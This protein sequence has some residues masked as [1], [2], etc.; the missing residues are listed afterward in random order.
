MPNQVLRNS[1][2]Q[3]AASRTYPLSPSTLTE[4]IQL[5]REQINQFPTA[6]LQA[7]A[8]RS[9]LTLFTGVFG[10]A[11]IAWTGWVGWLSSVGVESLGTALGLGALT[12]LV[13]L[14]VVVTNWAKG[15]R[16]WWD[17]WKRIQ[18]GFE[19]DLKVR[20]C[21]AVE[22]WWASNTNGH[23]SDAIGRCCGEAGDGCSSYS[24][25]RT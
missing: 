7:L 1:L 11:G 20:L 19:R 6:T 21:F 10:G 12:S 9:V 23:V 14:R 25:R 2:Q 22:L 13:V 4:P 15:K 3:I 24:M 5:R 18:A 16:R 17:D 8:Q